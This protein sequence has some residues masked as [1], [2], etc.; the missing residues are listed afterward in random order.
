MILQASYTCTISGLTWTNLPSGKRCPRPY[1]VT[2]VLDDDSLIAR[3]QTKLSDRDW[4]DLFRR[5]NGYDADHDDSTPIDG[6][7]NASPLAPT[8]QSEGP[9]RKK[10]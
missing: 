1:R 6:T 8:R 9:S 3:Q 10:P 2:D 7:T 5:E 4:R